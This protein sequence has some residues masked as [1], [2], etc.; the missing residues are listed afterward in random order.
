ME[1]GYVE[2]LSGYM[3]FMIFD[4][5]GHYQ[6]GMEMDIKNVLPKFDYKNMKQETKKKPISGFTVLASMED[7]WVGEVE[8]L[9]ATQ[10]SFGRHFKRSFVRYGLTM[11]IQVLPFPFQHRSQSQRLKVG[12]KSLWFLTCSL[13]LILY[14]QEW[15]Q[16]FV[17]FEHGVTQTSHI[18]LLKVRY[19]KNVPRGTGWYEMRACNNGAPHELVIN[20][21]FGL[22]F[23]LS[24]MMTLLLSLMLRSVES[25][26]TSRRR[27]PRESVYY[28]PDFESRLVV[29]K[30]MKSAVTMWDRRTILAPIRHQVAHKCHAA[31]NLPHVQEDYWL[32]PSRTWSFWPVWRAETSCT[33]MVYGC[34]WTGRTTSSS[35]SPWWSTTA[36]VN[37]TFGSHGIGCR[38][39]IFP[40]W[41]P[42]IIRCRASQRPKRRTRSQSIQTR[43][44]D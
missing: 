4:M 35:G 5:D 12:E 19:Y 1:I 37:C 15:Y 2:K 28:K 11:M 32:H 33:S 36:W 30:L 24:W 42:D 38:D 10:M 7:I 29:E 17:K 44:L 25:V 41:C 18:V 23:S 8:V 16:Y 3:V 14:I 26:L 40:E 43:R 9:D 6:Y 20:A 21:S 31:H 39:E 34:R 22:D 13:L 27:C